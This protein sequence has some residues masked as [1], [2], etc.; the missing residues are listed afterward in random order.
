MASDSSDMKYHIVNVR[1]GAH[2]A[3]LGDSDRSNVVNVTFNLADDGDRGSEVR[4]RL[5]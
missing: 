4:C 3:L 1:T 2:A 5:Q